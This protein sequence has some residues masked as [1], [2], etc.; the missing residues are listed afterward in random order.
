MSFSASSAAHPYLAGPGGT[1]Q[2]TNPIMRGREAI[3]EPEYLTDAFGREAVAFIERH[4]EEPWFLYLAFNAVHGPLQATDKYLTKFANIADEKRRTYAA[5]SAA[6]DDAVGTVLAKLREQGAE[7][8]TLIFFIADNGG[9][10]G[11]NGSDNGPLRGRKGQTWE[12]GVRVHWLVQWKGKLPAGKVYEQP[13]IQLDVLP[14]ALAAA[15]R[16]AGR[17]EA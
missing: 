10:E 2:G 11:V 8:N 5:M 15:G 17:V 7:E 16:N 9:P 4:K 1:S 13:V 6:L 12:G 3:D 14:T